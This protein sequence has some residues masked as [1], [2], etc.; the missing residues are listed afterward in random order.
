MVAS[1]PANP[2]LRERPVQRAESTGCYTAEGDGDS[3]F[4]AGQFTCAAVRNP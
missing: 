4:L 3:T 1:Q 2:G